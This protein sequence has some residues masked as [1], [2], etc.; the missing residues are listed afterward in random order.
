MAEALAETQDYFE[1][2]F[3]SAKNF[4]TLAVAA[5]DGGMPKEAAFLFHQATERLYQC[6][7]L[8]RTLYMPKTHNLNRLRSLAEDLEP[9]LKQV[10]PST[11]KDERQA[12]ARLREACIKARYSR[13]YRITAEQLAWLGERVAVLKSVVESACVERLN[14]LANAA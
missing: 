11:N 7:F 8:V 2:W 13:E 3:A 5:R 1:E 9:R 10:W 6:L 12:Y 14:T 4:E